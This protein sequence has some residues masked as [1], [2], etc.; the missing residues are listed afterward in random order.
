MEKE[1]AIVT[2]T[3]P[4]DLA[5]CAGAKQRKDLVDDNNVK[6]WLQKWPG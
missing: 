6:F 3:Y 4:D 5:L 1:N 2:I